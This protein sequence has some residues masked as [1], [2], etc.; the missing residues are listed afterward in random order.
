VAREILEQV[1]EVVRPGVLA[2][3][4]AEDLMAFLLQSVCQIRADLS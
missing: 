4:D 2:L 1:P 3:V